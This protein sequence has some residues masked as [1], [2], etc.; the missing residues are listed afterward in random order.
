MRLMLVRLVIG[1]LLILILATP[2]LYYLTTQFYAEDLIEI[3]CSY[4]IK[5]PNIDLHNDVLMGVGIQFTV[6]LIALLAMLFIVM[7]FVPR[8]LWFPFY[9][10][11]A[12]L[13]TFQ[14]EK[15]I[16]HLENSTGVKEFSQLN[17]TLTKIMTSSVRSYQVQKEF[18]EN[19]SHELQTPLAIVQ[20]KI[21]N[22]LQ[23]ANLTAEQAHELHEMYQALRHM[24]NLSRNLLLLSKIEN[25]QFHKQQ[26]IDLPNKLEQIMPRLE[27]I[28]GEITILRDFRVSHLMLSC[29][30][31]LLECLITNLFVNAVR[32]NYPSGKILLSLNS[33][34]LTIMNT[35]KEEALDS[36]Q[37]FSRFYRIKDS[38]KGNGLGLAIVKSI[39]DFHSWNI[40]YH[41]SAGEHSFVITF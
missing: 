16:V 23:D 24:S 35:S 29:D 37:V 11:L 40:S 17:E 28:A 7:H 13:R 5:N 18:T 4:G 31:T 25:G 22:L 1:L 3:I 12:Q 36:S 39:C 2:L 38:Q 14:V 21:D 26:Q 9:D 41:Y 34:S 15:G 8:R 30:E 19:A 10:T 20:N 6:L 32:H 27:S 33:T